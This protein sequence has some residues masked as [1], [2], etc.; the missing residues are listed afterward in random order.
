MG[1]VALMALFVAA[2]SDSDSDDGLCFATLFDSC[3]VDEYCH[4]PDGSC[5]DF[6]EAGECRPRPEICAELYSPTCGCDGLIYSNSCD[7]S[8][9]GVS[10]ANDDLC[11]YMPPIDIPHDCDIDGCP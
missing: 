3:A 5:G 11:L 7:A 2:C 9:S 8:A 6:G 4:F 10:V 1:L